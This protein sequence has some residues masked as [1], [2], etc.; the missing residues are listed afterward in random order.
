VK[1]LSNVIM[2]HVE[3]DE[4]EVEAIENIGFASNF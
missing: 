2:K 1:D 4:T 3:A